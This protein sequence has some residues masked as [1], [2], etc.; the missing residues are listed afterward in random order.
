MFTDWNPRNIVAECRRHWWSNG[1]VIMIAAIWLGVQSQ[2]GQKLAILLLALVAAVVVF[3]FMF[4]PN[5]RLSIRNAFVP[6]L[7]CSNLAPYI[8]ITQGLPKV[9]L[10]FLLIFTAWGLILV[11]YFVTGHRLKIRNVPALK[12]FAMF[13]ASITFS[14]FYSGIILEQTVIPRDYFELF[15]VFNYVVIFLFVA[16]LDIPPERILRYYILTLILMALSALFGLAQFFNVG[17]VNTAITPY[18]AAGPAKLV[19]LARHG[20]IIGTAPNPNEFGAAM[21]L[22][23]NM[24]FALFLFSPWQRVRIVAVAVF[25]TTVFALFLTLS[26]TSFVALFVGLTFLIFWRYPAQAGLWR[27]LKRYATMAIIMLIGA[28]L[29]YISLP[30]KFFMR[31]GE[32]QDINKA[33]SFMARL[34]LWRTH[35]ALW[36]ESRFFGRGP[37]KELHSTIVDNEWLLLLRRYGIVGVTVFAMLMLSFYRGLSAIARL[38]A[39]RE[40]QSLCNALQ[41]TLVAYSVYMIAASIYHSLKLMPLLLVML[42]LAFTQW[43]AKSDEPSSGKSAIQR[44]SPIK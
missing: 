9:R 34:D 15:K 28:S 4:F 7:L 41:A 33:N 26:R 31:I 10:E 18:Y 22:G 23:A 25:F 24:A 21:I 29:I 2:L 16:S 13:G 36:T 20:R 11:D 43:R 19:A 6:V 14:T 42:G 44:R 1:I 12:W 38:S 40:I 30:E 3:L 5:G 8:S 35:Y 39:A 17:D 27:A 37:A 32:L